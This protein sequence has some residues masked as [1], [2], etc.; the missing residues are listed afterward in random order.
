M[1]EGQGE[2]IFA[3]RQEL[4]D[5]SREE[6][7]KWFYDRK[8][9]PSLSDDVMQAEIARQKGEH[10][11]V[12]EVYS[13]WSS[14]A[15]ARLKKLESRRKGLAVDLAPQKDLLKVGF[16]GLG[17]IRHVDTN[18]QLKADPDKKDVLL[19][20]IGEVRK[21]YGLLGLETLV[22]WTIHGGP[23]HWLSEVAQDEVNTQKIRQP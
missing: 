3:W 10:S 15:E 14:Q 18:S 5:L 9:I 7:A 16:A 12:G 8:L 20:Q 1:K 13:H 11:R 2:N 6:R 23:I 17:R 4:R 21:L 22:P 19:S